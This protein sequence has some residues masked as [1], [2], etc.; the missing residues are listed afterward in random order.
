LLISK[1]IKL[2]FRV[3]QEALNSVKCVE[4]KESVDIVHLI[5][6]KDEMCRTCYRNTGLYMVEL[7]VHNVRI[8]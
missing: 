5:Q 2:T 6:H 7:K 8:F 3:L 1:P 4:G